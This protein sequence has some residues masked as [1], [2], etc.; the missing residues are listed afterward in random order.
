[1]NSYLTEQS[2]RFLPLAWSIH[3]NSIQER[4]SC[5]MSL[6]KSSPREGNLPIKL[7][8]LLGCLLIL[9]ILF[10][11]IGQV[12]AAAAP[13]P[14]HQPD[15]MRGQVAPQED[16]TL[17]S[18][19][20]TA[21]GEP[22]ALVPQFDPATTIYTATVDAESVSVSATA[23]GSGAV[24]DLTAVGDDTT[25]LD[26]LSSTASAQADLPEGATTVVSMRVRAADDATTETYHVLLSRP[27]DPSIPD[28]TI[29]AENSEYVA[30]IGPLT[31]TL[32]RDGD[33]ADSLDVNVNVVQAQEWLSD[34]SE[35]ATFAVGDSETALIIP[36]TEF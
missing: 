1:M 34:L 21:S 6:H 15:S 8:P 36:A 9:A 11:S 24:I 18:L 27:A 10:S 31:F 7:I 16:A 3:H 22:V 30:G 26:P 12:S 28:I 14:L 5:N 35:T 19:S 13:D 20:V 2:Q 29:E 32:T 23:A 25:D 17:S 4:G 33:T